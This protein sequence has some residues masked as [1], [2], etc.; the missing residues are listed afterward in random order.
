MKYIKIYQ[1]FINEEIDFIISA[2][3]STELKAAKEELQV[4]KDNIKDYTDKKPKIDNIFKSTKDNSEIDKKISELIG[5]DKGR[6][7]FITDYLSVSSDSKRVQ[8]LLSQIVDNK[9]NIDDYKSLIQSSTNDFQKGQ[10]NLKIT[11]LN[12]KMSDANTSISKIKSDIFNKS[13][14]ISDDMKRI[15]KEMES[16]IKILSETRTS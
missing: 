6:N 7:P 1:T 4:F 5:K 2:G 14:K 16:K 13:K 11:D 9:L 12:K 3:D 15:Q 10:I 8:D